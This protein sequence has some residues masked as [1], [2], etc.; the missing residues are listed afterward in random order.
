MRKAAAVSYNS[1]RWYLV[2]CTSGTSHGDCLSQCH[3]YYTA[4]KHTGLA[5]DRIA[6][7]S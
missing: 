4:T 1:V 7:V 5:W 6:V 2:L 3:T